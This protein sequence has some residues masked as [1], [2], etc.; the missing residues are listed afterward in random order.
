MIILLFYNCFEQDRGGYLPTFS[1]PS[2]SNIYRKEK[3]TMRED[4]L[5]NFKKLSPEKQQELIVLIKRFLSN[6]QSV[7][8][9][10][11]QASRNKK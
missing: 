8:F 5:N 2:L 9:D 10:F 7:F 6:Y 1:L 4:T 11:H 3:R